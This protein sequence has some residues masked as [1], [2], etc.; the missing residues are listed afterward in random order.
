MNIAIILA[1][2]HGWRLSTGSQKAFVEVMGRPLLYFSLKTFLTHEDIDEVIVVTPPNTLGEFN[3]VMELLGDSHVIRVTGGKTRFQSLKKALSQVK[4]AQNILIHNAANPLVT[5]NEISAVLTTLEKHEAAAIATPAY[6][7][8]RKISRI[9]TEVIPRENV[10][11][12]QTPQGL[13]YKT[14]KKGI[15]LI[16]HDPTDDLQ[17]AEIQGI[18]PKIIPGTAQNFKITTNEDLLLLEDILAGHRDFTAGLGEDSHAFATRGKLVLGGIKFDKFPKL[19]AN[20]DG[21]VMIHALVTAILQALGLG[22]L[23]EFAKSDE[24]NSINFLYRA[25]NLM[26]DEGWHIAKMSF[27]FEGSRPR[28]DKI[29]RKLQKS[30]AALC[31]IENEQVSV[32]GHSGEELTSF[33]R[34][35]GLKCQCLITLE[36]LCYS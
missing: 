24:K 22:S 8:L 20:S 35:K 15:D 16:Q 14:L 10:W 28:F 9:H 4:K 27:M 11:R 18:K 7:T 13:N 23:G 19:K 32:A 21:D 30:I 3:Q 31:G 2:G 33:G 5:Y 6:D 26:E 1:A 36:R 25:L 29:G 34:G 12:M 17:L